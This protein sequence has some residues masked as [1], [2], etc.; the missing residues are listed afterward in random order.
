[1]K[2][3]PQQLRQGE[4]CLPLIS[5][6]PSTPAAAD[7]TGRLLSSFGVFAFIPLASLSRRKICVVSSAGC[8]WRKSKLKCSLSN[9][10]CAK[11]LGCCRSS[12]PLWSE[13][14]TPPECVK[15]KSR[16]ATVSKISFQQAMTLNADLKYR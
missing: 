10:L 6:H 8:A 16:K 14:L 4:S 1:M 7:F 11:T 15:A 13:R 2:N 12:G 9:G 5:A 3:K